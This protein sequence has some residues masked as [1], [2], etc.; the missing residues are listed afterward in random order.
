MVL[1]TSDRL[2]FTSEWPAG[3]ESPVGAFFKRESVFRISINNM[4]QNYL[5]SIDWLQAYCAGATL[6]SGE[7]ISSAVG[8][9]LVFEEE[10]GTANF[11]KRFT[12]SCNGIEVATVLQCPKMGA[13]ARDLTEVKLHNRVLYTCEPARYLLNIIDALRLEYRGIARIDLCCDVNHLSGGRSVE[14]LISRFVHT[15]EGDSNHLIRRGSAKYNLHGN[16]HR[17]A[18]IKHESIK[19]GSPQADVV[20]YI[21]NKSLE[22]ISEKDKPWIRDCWKS[23]GLVHLVDKEGLQ[24]LSAKELEARLNDSG[25]SEFVRSGV[26]RFEISIKS[27]GK[28]IINLSQDKLFRLELDHIGTQI[29]VEELFKTYAEKYF[30]FR[31]PR[32]KKRI[33]DYSTITLFDYDKEVH[34]RPY[35]PSVCGDTGRFDHMVVN[36]INKSMAKYSDLASPLIASLQE[37]KDFI[38]SIAGAKL[39]ETK[40]K[41]YE[42]YL[43]TLKGETFYEELMRAAAR[44]PEAFAQMRDEYREFLA[45]H[46]SEQ[47]K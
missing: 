34:Y 45:L 4:K 26:W 11:A 7:V 19:F 10:G 46:H 36:Y 42:S 40:K 14:D 27:H 17:R 30:D 28:D 23:A 31:E 47:S 18:K 12:I 41:Q 24:S 3:V 44:Y 20:P 22:L 8:T 6:S 1:G 25:I 9:L 13:L 2:S 5:I 39:Y 33:R 37:T 38:A 21:Y 43:D 29:G 16:N 15:R 35:R 32:G